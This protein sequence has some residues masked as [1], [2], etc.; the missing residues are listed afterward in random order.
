[1]AAPFTNAGP[2]IGQS[3]LYNLSG[4]TVPAMIY[5]VNATTWAV[6]LVYFNASG[7]TSVTGVAYD[8]ALGSG[9]WR[10]PAFL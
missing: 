6:S 8:P 10:W 1:M 3:I 4:T 9:N 7:A 5:S 2:Q